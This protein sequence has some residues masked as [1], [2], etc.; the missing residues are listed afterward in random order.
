MKARF[1]A[2]PHR[3][4]TRWLLGLCA[5]AIAVPLLVL[6][7]QLGVDPGSDRRSSRPAGGAAAVE[8]GAL[9]ARAGNC[10]GCHTMRGGQ[11]YAGG[12]AIVTPF[13][14]IVASNLT[15]DAETGLGR[16]TADDFWRA[17]HNGKSRDGRLL[18]PAFP[19][20]NYTQVTR[21]DA[22]ALYAYLRT[23]P[24]VK[25]QNREHR[26]AF[27]YNQPVV[28]AFWRTLY[29]RPGEYQRDARQSDEWN[30]GAY[31]VQGLGHCGA[32]HT[33]RNALGGSVTRRDLSGGIIPALNWHA[34][35]L[36]GGSTALGDW[37]T[38]DIVDLLATGVSARGAAFGPMAE[39]V[40]S[41]L[42]HVPAHDL[43]AMAVY[44]K[45]LP[46]GAPERSG[47]TPAVSPDDKAVLARGAA[48]YEQHCVECHGANGRGAAPAY[49][50][51]TNAT[52]VR[53]GPPLNAI[54]MVLNGGFPPSTAGNPRPYGMPPFGAALDDDEVAAL[55]SYL[56]RRWSQQAELVS[57]N[58]VRR[59]RGAAG[60]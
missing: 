26:L 3:R 19:Y 15:P 17:L 53:A 5:V 52:S 29:F 49:P 37:R 11:P 28:L 44:L 10:I 9:L 43:R 51:L 30:R 60:D 7:Y 36:T 31:L 2:R 4:R 59:A 13:G 41:S 40:G 12:R 27:P 6:G 32:C 39:V 55:V 18:Y 34:P 24:P 16:W 22:D 48:L 57:A 20:P 23:V 8:R 50:A 54:R 46:A 42:Q 56:R 21:E 1:P 33:P 58:E 47:A 25:Q 38:E 45:S 14:D 35:A